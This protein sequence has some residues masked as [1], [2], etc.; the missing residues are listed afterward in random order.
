MGINI[1]SVVSL[2]IWSKVE[3]KKKIAKIYSR[4]QSFWFV[5][6]NFNELKKINNNSNSSNSNNNNNNT[7]FVAC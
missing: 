1:V 6:L 7:P 4:K 5:I 3:W 2:L